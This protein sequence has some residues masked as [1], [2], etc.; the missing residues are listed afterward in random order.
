MSKHI[1]WNTELMEDKE[2]HARFRQALYTSIM[3]E[4]KALEA[5]GRDRQQDPMIFDLQKSVVIARCT[6]LEQYDDGDYLGMA[7]TLAKIESNLGRFVTELLEPHADRG[8]RVFRA[9]KDSP[10]AQQ[11]DRQL[12]ERNREIAAARDA[13][14]DE[15][16][17]SHKIANILAARGEDDWP[18]TAKGIRDVLKKKRT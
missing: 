14:L 7:A 17:R 10:A 13:L 15:G 6:A 5:F 9:R 3:S 2:R 4:L 11:H 1:P 8:M 16:V 12:L 18:K